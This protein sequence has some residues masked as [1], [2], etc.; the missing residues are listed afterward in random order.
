MN[1]DGDDRGHFRRN[2]IIIALLHSLVIGGLLGFS[3]WKNRERPDQQI[4]WL[5]GGGMPV[6]AAD[7][8]QS[9]P[10]PDD[11][12]QPAQPPQETPTP[13][14]APESTPTPD[15]AASQ[16]ARSRDADTAAGARFDH[17]DAHTGPNCHAA[18]DSETDPIRYAVAHPEAETQAK[19]F[20]K[21]VAAQTE[22]KA[23]RLAAQT[24]KPETFPAQEPQPV[25]PGYR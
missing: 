13:E 21:A 5:D 10:T 24:R 9:A 14:P 16:P 8:S 18:S 3:M 23:L 20:A 6:A 19:S 22:T 12:D 7:Q 25:G 17:P 4:S 1:P 11:T 2:L 15:G